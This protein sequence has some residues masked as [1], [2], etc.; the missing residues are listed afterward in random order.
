[1]YPC[2]DSYVYRGFTLFDCVQPVAAVVVLAS[3]YSA[4]ADSEILGPD[5]NAERVLTSDRKTWIA[6]KKSPKKSLQNSDVSALCE[7]A[8]GLF[9]S[10]LD[11]KT[12]FLRAV[13]SRDTADSI[14]G[15][16]AMWRVLE[17]RGPLH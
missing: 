17:T 1:M 8:C 9:L 6:E 3:A 15:Q 12:Y 13:Q 10:T 7:V 5:S 16:S 11:T 2:T 14:F 4:T